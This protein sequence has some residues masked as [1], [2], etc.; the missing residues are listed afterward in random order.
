[1]GER[2]EEEEEEK[3]SKQKEED[4]KEE[5]KTEAEESNVDEG[6]KVENAQENGDREGNDGNFNESQLD[7]NLIEKENKMFEESEKDYATSEEIIHNVHEMHNKVAQRENVSDLEV[8][9]KKQ[10]STDEDIVKNNVYDVACKTA[11]K[12]ISSLEEN[13]KGKSLNDLL[14]ELGKEA[15]EVDNSMKMLSRPESITEE[16]PEE[17][18]ED[19][20]T[21]KLDEE[22]SMTENESS[23]PSPSLLE[24][25]EPDEEEKSEEI[26]NATEESIEIPDSEDG[27]NEKETLSEETNTLHLKSTPSPTKEDPTRAEVK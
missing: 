24:S 12:V 27:E 6:S 20:Q 22:T 10:E 11:F 18:D 13:V 25:T 21:M 19:T 26:A 4:D 1:M 23:P 15:D 16:K 3:Q 9:E 14:L 7:E 2:T 5:G 8:G 17:T